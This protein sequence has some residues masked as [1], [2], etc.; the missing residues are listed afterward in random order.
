MNPTAAFSNIKL[1]SAQRNPTISQKTPPNVPNI[2]LIGI[3]LNAVQAA[4]IKMHHVP[5][6]FKY[7]LRS[8]VGVTFFIIIIN[9]ARERLSLLPF[10][11]LV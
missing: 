7:Q 4:P 1:L 6:H 3:T 11:Y 10:L 5:H 9:V 2:R 8:P